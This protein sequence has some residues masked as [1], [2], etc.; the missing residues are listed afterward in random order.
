MNATPSP[1]S[2]VRRLLRVVAALFVASALTLGLAAYSFLTLSSEASLLR[3]EVMAA[4]GTEWKTTVQLSVGR[5][6]LWALRTGLVFFPDARMA[7][8]REALGAVSSVSVGVYRNAAAGG[9]AGDSS[10]VDAAGGSTASLFDAAD[11]LMRLRGW[12]R[13]V[14]VSDAREKVL[15]YMPTGVG[16]PTEVCLAVMKRRE[17]VVVSASLDAASL[18]TMA[19]RHLP[20]RHAS[21]L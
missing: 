5:C 20:A 9:A 14:G 1:A 19:G 7:E 15:I 17:L 3:R 13:V 4:S 12:T 6:T 11:R 8:V 21:V 2:P 10:R 18:A 16:E